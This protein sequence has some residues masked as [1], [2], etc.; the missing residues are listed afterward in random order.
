MGKRQPQKKKGFNPKSDKIPLKLQD[1]I[2]YDNMNFSWRVSNSY[3]DYKHPKFGWDKVPILYFLQKIVQRLQSY[4]GS[5]WHDVKRDHRCHP[6]GLDNIPK[7]CYA[8]LEERQIGVDEL[9]QIPLGGI[10]RIIGYKLG[11]TF[12]LMWWDSEHKF[13]PTKAN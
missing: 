10:P 4:E 8:R 6:W 9:Y 12:F 13:C 2:S 11:S 5:I 3:M 1:P 7:E